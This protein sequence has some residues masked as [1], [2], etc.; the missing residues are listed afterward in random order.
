MRFR[1]RSGFRS[2]CRLRCWWWSDWYRVSLFRHIGRFGGISGFGSAGCIGR[3]TTEVFASCVFHIAEEHGHTIFL[4]LVGL[5][6]GEC[7][8]GKDDSEDGMHQN[9]DDTSLYLIFLGRIVIHRGKVVEWQEP[10]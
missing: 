6:H 4:V 8:D 10:S 2:R 3:Q 9:G 5:H 1:S 7:Q